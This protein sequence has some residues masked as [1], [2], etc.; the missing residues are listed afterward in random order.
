MKE[1]IAINGKKK[2]AMDNNDVVT[3]SSRFPE[4]GVHVRL[5]LHK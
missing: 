2:K 4:R 1:K 5:K 3:C